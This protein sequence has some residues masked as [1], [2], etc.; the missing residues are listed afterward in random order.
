MVQNLAMMT[1]RTVSFVIDT[2]VAPAV[3]D[4]LFK[5]IHRHYLVPQH[6]RFK[7]VRRTTLNH[8]QILTFTAL[9][10]E[11]KWQI[12]VGMRAEKPIHVKMTPSDET[13]PQL[14]LDQ[15]RE[16]LF[17]GVELFEERIRKTT[18]YFAWV[19]GKE[20]IPEKVPLKRRRFAGR[21]LFENML[22]LFIIFLVAS[23]VL[24]IFLGPY[25]PIAVVAVQFVV[26][27]FSAK[28]ISRMGEWTISAKNPNVHLLQYHLPIDEHKGFQK[29]YGKD[30]LLNMKKEIYE[31][32]FGA[33]KE[34]N[35][36]TAEE[37]LSKYGFK[38]V[39][40]NMST[41][42]VNVYQIVKNAAEKFRLPIPKIII[43]NTILPNAAASGPS[44]KHGIV[45]ITT[46]LLVQLE[47]D[48]IFSVVGH[49]FSHLKGRDPLALFALMSSEY[50]LRIY[51]L[52]PIVLFFGLFYIIFAMGALYFVAKF[53]EARA[54]LESAI[55]IGQPQV[56]AEALRKI[57]FR[58]LQLERVSAYRF[59]DWIGWDPH[60]PIYFR[61]ERLEKMQASVKVKHPFIRSIKDTVNGFLAIL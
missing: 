42:T 19:E 55:R 21:I 53:F 5:F 52:W 18:L 41:K 58:R 14:A 39:P 30:T 56:L 9:D 8:Q 35:C 32:T 20:V 13:V 49:E 16:D 57:G 28:I 1:E 61:I 27:L 10:P 44:P 23:I 4:D 36:Q 38:C 59:Q 47:D 37:A 2:D 22:F 50:L 45:L 26:T 6:K 12:D 29:K 24:F 40:E 54:D 25:A 46:G 60:P 3:L 11:G 34:L 31:K 17:I 7:N 33:G 43:S 51:V 48:E 15:L